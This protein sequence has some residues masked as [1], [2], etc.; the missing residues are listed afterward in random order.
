LVFYHFL[1]ALKIWPQNSATKF[2][3]NLSLEFS[4]FQKIGKFFGLS[5][6]NLRIVARLSFVKNQYSGLN[7]S[8][9]AADARMMDRK[10]AKTENEKRGCFGRGRFTAT[11]TKMLLKFPKIFL[12]FALFWGYFAKSVFRA[13]KTWS[14]RD[15]EPKINPWLS[16]SHPL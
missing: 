12:N 9:S 11:K 4:I 3:K 13:L 5:I 6:F 2:E 14:R 16:Q 7:W 10:G 8:T 1:L 15:H